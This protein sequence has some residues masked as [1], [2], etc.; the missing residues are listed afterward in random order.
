MKKLIIPL[1]LF[2]QF[3]SIQKVSQSYDVVQKTGLQNLILVENAEFIDTV[4]SIDDLKVYSKNEWINADKITKGEGF[5]EVSPLNN[6]YLQYENGVPY[7]PIGPN[8]CW[9]RTTTNPDK[10]LKQY[11]YYFKKMSENGA[12]FTRIWLGAPLWEFEHE[13]VGEFD[14]IK[15]D[16]LLD[17]LVNLATNYGI[18][19]KFCIHNFR[20][21][22]ESPPIFEGSVSM[23]RPMYN[24]KN[25][26]PLETMDEYFGTDK[27]K[28]LF[29]ERMNF[30]SK[31]Y[32]NNPTVFGWELWNEI[33]A[34]NTSNKPE[35]ILE[36][37]AWMLP[38]AKE[39]FPR[40]LVMQSMGSFDRN[41]SRKWYKEFCIMN[42]NDIAQVHRYLDSGAELDV[43]KGP[44][45]ILAADATRELLSYNPGKP[46]I[47]SEVG[48]VEA[49]HAGPSNLY[50]VDSLGILLHD[51]IFAPFFSGSASPG[52]SWHWHFY[53]DKHD[54]WWHY[55]RFEQVVKDINPILEDFKPLFVETADVRVY[56]LM[57]ETTTLIWC[58]D[59][60][61]NWQT[62]LIDKIQPNI[63]KQS[64]SLD[65]I[66]IA[67]KN[68]KTVKFFD[69]WKNKWTSGDTSGSDILIPDF[70]RS[71]ILKI[72]Y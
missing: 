64:V 5:I 67:D 40:H 38:K 58:R 20:T 46:V 63:L 17:S 44:M 2:F 28:N 35:D 34:V 70:T 51:L 22:T 18:K 48:A 69:P 65:Q 24:K 53:I 36:W 27:G 12:N 57:G 15:S 23:G 16:Y 52:Q 9:S 71:I 37:T 72:T 4:R 47:V 66:G 8:I 68:I 21:L 25:G 3:T 26:G 1:L 42:N 30:L 45:D 56:I 60:N 55:G 59:A 43:C 49:N 54:L 32:G 19:L 10:A 13:R 14:I 33:N 39:I 50:D 7:V 61:N 41:A 6:R 62:E 29:L 31:K 11:N